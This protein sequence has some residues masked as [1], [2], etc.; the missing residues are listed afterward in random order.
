MEHIA[1]RIYA[2]FHP[3]KAWSGLSAA[4]KEPWLKL[5][6]MGADL[7]AQGPHTDTLPETPPDTG[8][9]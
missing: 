3:S 8:R 2:I 1:E 5:A 7:A 6:Q 4:E 9:K